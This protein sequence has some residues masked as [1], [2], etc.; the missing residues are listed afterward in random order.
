MDIGPP[1]EGDRRPLPGSGAQQ[2]DP[3]ELARE[4]PDGSQQKKSFKRN[5]MSVTEISGAVRVAESDPR[6]SIQAAELDAHPE[7]LNSPTGV[8]DLHRGTVTRH[9]ASLLLTRITAD[10]VQI[11]A[12]HPGLGCLPGRDL[13]R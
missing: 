8:V 2:I 12:P 5:S 4:L 10:G 13:Q 7:R 3:T 1:D 9:D 6:V 11:D